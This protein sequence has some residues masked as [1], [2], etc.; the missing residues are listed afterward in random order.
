MSEGGDGWDGGEGGT[1][2]AFEHD[3]PAFPCQDA[4]LERDFVEKHAENRQ[5]CPVDHV[6]LATG[7]QPA[8][9]PSVWSPATRTP[10]ACWAARSSVGP[11]VWTRP[12]RRRCS[13]RR[14]PGGP[15]AAGVRFVVQRSVKAVL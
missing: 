1:A 6:R 8:W 13:A 14:S 7:G 2:D 12:S 11:P 5:K 10:E 15:D 4:R 9:S 3:L